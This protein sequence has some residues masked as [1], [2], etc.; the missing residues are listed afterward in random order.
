MNTQSRMFERGKPD[1]PSLGG[2]KKSVTIDQVA[3]QA[4]VSKTTVSRFLNGR[5]DALSNETRERASTVCVHRRVT[6]FCWWTAVTTLSGSAWGSG[7]C[8]KIRWMG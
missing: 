1:M 4:G 8:W 2:R 7:I 5:Y 6:S 3:A